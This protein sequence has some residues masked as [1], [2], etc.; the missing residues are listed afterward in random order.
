M[1]LFIGLTSM[2]VV[3]Q[4]N[5]G[6]KDNYPYWT[7]SKDVQKLQYRNV[8]FMPAKVNIGDPARTT[9]K[10]AAQLAVSTEKRGTVATSGY[11]TWMISKGAARQQMERTGK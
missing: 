5:E 10:G 2:P 6:K 8:I 9:G 11:P 3:A 7:I 4:T 1:I